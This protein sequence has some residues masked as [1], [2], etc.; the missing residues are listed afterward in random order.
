MQTPTPTRAAESDC[1]HQRAAGMRISRQLA[2]GRLA[3]GSAASL[4]AP[5]PARRS[6]QDSSS[7]AEEEDCCWIC[8]QGGSG[9]ALEQP[10]GCPR[11]SHR[12]CLS[13]WQLQ[14]VGRT[15]EA[16]CRCARSQGTLTQLAM[17]HQKM[18]RV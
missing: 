17:K 5:A 13:R 14:S 18:H 9:E 11:L 1:Q 16:A 8:L 15:E 3:A 10:C 4:A 7:G 2:A 6:S 12:S